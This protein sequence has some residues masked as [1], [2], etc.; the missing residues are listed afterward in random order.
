M[1]RRVYLLLIFAAPLSLTLCLDAQQS[2]IVKLTVEKKP[3]ALDGRAMATVKGPAKVKGKVVIT[4]KTGRIATQAIQAWIVLDGQGA[5]LLLSPEKKGLPN[6]LRY[7]EL[8]AGKS[9]L[10]G[11]LA[12]Q[13]ATIAERKPANDQ[14]AFALSGTD[15]ESKQPV[16]FAWDTH[17]IHARIDDASQPQFSSDSLSYQTAGG[18]HTISMADLVALN[19]QTGVYA[20]PKNGA[21]PAYLEFLPSGD[22]LTI[23]STGEVERG[24]WIRAGP[25]FQVPLPRARPRC[26]HKLSCNR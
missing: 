6:R 7:Y 17:A 19:Y 16:I 4:E 25:N 13:E 14:W 5:L 3:G 26:G 20:P 1:A 9:R 12:L 2:S 11:H 18:P 22:S 10:L 21:N 8:D 24:R 15:P 23:S